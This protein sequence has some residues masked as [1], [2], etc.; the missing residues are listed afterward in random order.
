MDKFRYLGV[1]VTNTNDIREEIKH[2]INMGNACY[3]LEKILSS[4][5]LS[6]I[7]KVKTFKTIIPPVALYGYE[8]CSLTL[9]N[10]QRFR[11]FEN[12]VLTVERYFRISVE[13]TG[14]WRNLHNTELHPLYSSLNIIRNLKS[15]TEYGR[16]CTVPRKEESRIAYDV[17]VD[18]SE[19]NRPLSRSKRRLENNIKI[20]LWSWAVVLGTGWTL[21]EIGSNGG[22]M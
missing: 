21:L 20:D 1:T 17:L 13:T 9:I 22:L 6:K 15:R 19:E 16:T 5:V 11:V 18:R 7:L 12:K 2:R 10:E 4:R 8:T 14:E 3:S